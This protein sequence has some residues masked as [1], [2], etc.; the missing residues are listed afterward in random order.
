MRI[1]IGVLTVLLL[2]KILSLDVKKN[3]QKNCHLI[4]IWWLVSFQQFFHLSG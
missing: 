3:N 4:E 1:Q 2:Q